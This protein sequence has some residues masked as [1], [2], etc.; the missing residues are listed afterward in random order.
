MI[1]ANIG[2]IGLAVMGGIFSEGI[3]L[4]GERVIGVIVVGCGVPQVC[5]EREII[6]D[7]Y[8]ENGEDGY[9]FAYRNP[10]MNKV[11]QAAGRLIRTDTDRG[12]IFLLDRR[13]WQSGYR[14]LFPRE[15]ADARR[16]DVK[17]AGQMAKEFWEG[18]DN[19]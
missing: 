11:M 3:D 4:A 9:A 6:R 5:T 10:G 14:A 16:T 15:W 2:L 12:V 19:G 18:M 7:F 1:K 13:L 17:T 8:R